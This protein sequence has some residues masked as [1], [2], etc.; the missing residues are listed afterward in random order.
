MCREGM[1]PLLTGQRS[2]AVGLVGDE[3]IRGVLAGEVARQDGPGH[4]PRRHV[5][6]A[7]HA[8][9]H[10]LVLRKTEETETETGRRHGETGDPGGRE[11]FF[12]SDG[13]RNAMNVFLCAWLQEF[14]GPVWESGFWC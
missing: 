8:D 1:S 13:S 10:V 4:D 2:D 9:V 14:P 3:G 5:L 6:H 7:V 12:Q 11:S